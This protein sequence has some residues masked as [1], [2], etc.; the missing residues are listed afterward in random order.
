[1]DRCFCAAVAIFAWTAATPAAE[2]GPREDVM[3]AA[4]RCFALADDRAWLDCYF[5]AAQPMQAALAAPRLP[6]AAP[7]AFAS[8]PPAA[9][10]TG[11]PPPANSSSGFGVSRA[12]GDD[13]P[14]TPQDFDRRDIAKAPPRQPIDHL[15]ARV[16]STSFSPRGYLRV[17]LDNGQVWEQI[18]GDTVTT[19]KLPPGNYLATIKIGFFGSYDLTIKGFAGLYRV[20]RVS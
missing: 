14:R 11:T 12:S 15:T 9:P 7:P 1:M 3:G 2:A 20:H 17:V 19:L 10:A 16:V 8:M 6:Q 4:A 13:R 5:K 18:D